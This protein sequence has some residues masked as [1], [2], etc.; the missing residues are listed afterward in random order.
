VLLT[1]HVI[2]LAVD[3]GFVKLTGGF[4][5]RRKLAGARILAERGMC[6]SNCLLDGVPAR[7]PSRMSF[8]D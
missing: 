4:V 8:W 1:V 3:G 5:E 2:Y 6:R 7:A